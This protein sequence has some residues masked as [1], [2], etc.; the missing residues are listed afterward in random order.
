MK[1]RLILIS[2][3][4]L[5]LISCRKDDIVDIQNEIFGTWK[6]TKDIII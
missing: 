4:F 6:M 3:L 1:N 5:V 2:V